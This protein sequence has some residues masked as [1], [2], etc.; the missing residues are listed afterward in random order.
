MIVKGI[1]EG[2]VIST[3]SLPVKNTNSNHKI[4]EVVAAKEEDEGNQKDLYYE[5]IL[6]MFIIES[7][8]AAIQCISEIHRD[9][10]NNL[11]NY[12]GAKLPPA[13]IPTLIL[14]VTKLPY[15]SR[16]VS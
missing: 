6:V 12:L 16:F 5:E 2:V 4:E 11:R 8:M 3:Y 13:F 7:A 1:Q 14:P 10:L 9:Q 15:T